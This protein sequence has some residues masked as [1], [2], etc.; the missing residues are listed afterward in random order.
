MNVAAHASAASSRRRRGVLALSSS[1]HSLARRA[2]RAS[3]HA[4]GRADGGRVAGELPRQP[5]RFPRERGERGE[6]HGPGRPQDGLV[7]KPDEPE[8]REQRRPQEA[9]RPA[10]RRLAGL[11]PERVALGRRPRVLE[12]DVRVV[13]RRPGVP[14]QPVDPLNREPRQHRDAHRDG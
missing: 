10:R 9:R 14:D 4:N 6:R 5:P 11:E 8:G 7:A 1:T 2:L 3:S 13:E 12:V